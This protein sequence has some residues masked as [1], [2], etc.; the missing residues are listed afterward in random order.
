V[1]RKNQNCAPRTVHGARVVFGSAVPST[2]KVTNT[3]M[4]ARVFSIIRLKFAD[5]FTRI[6]TAR[7]GLST[8]RVLVFKRGYNRVNHE[9]HFACD[10]Q[11]SDPPS[12]G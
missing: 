6:K 3:R 4:R 7:R 9:H 8:G 11:G 5:G 2:N 12:R 1:D 10:P